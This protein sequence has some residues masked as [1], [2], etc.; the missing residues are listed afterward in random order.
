VEAAQGGRENK[1]NGRA[2]CDIAVLLSIVLYGAM[3]YSYSSRARAKACRQNINFMWLLQGDPPPHGMINASRKHL[4]RGVIE[5]LLYDLVRLL[6]NYGEVM[7]THM[8]ID[9]TMLEVRAN[10]H[11]VVWRKNVDRYEEGQQEKIRGIPGTQQKW[12]N[13]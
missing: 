2:P 8:F 1:K 5:K 6:G 9:G 3:E 13:T 12:G 4:A 10:S 11:T 7:F